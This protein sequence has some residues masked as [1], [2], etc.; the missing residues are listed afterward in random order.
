MGIILI[1]IGIALLV[2][3]KVI[4]ITD[5]T[6]SAMGWIVANWAARIVGICLIVGGLCLLG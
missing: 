5:S 3:S 1:L 2:F 4:H 6:I